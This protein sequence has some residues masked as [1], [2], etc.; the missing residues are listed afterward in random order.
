VLQTSSFDFFDNMRPDLLGFFLFA[1][2]QGALASPVGPLIKNGPQLSETDLPQSPSESHLPPR[3]Y[4]VNGV[5]GNIAD[6]NWGSTGTIGVTGKEQICLL[7]KYL[8]TF[9]R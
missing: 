4:N 8:C 3:D 9:V 2:I 5:Q 1:F 6:F 7:G